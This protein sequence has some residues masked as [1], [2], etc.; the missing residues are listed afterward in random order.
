MSQMLDDLRIVC[1]ANGI[2]CTPADCS[3]AIA[4][5]RSSSS[6]SSSSS[7]SDSLSVPVFD[8]IEE[9]EV[10]LTRLSSMKVFCVFRNLRILRVLNQCISRIE[11][12]ER[13][14]QLQELWLPGNDITVIEGLDHCTALHTLILNENKIASVQGLSHLKQLTVLDLHA[15]QLATLDGI[16]QLTSLKRLNVAQNQ[17]TEAAQFLQSCNQLNEINLAGNLIHSPA[18]LYSIRDLDSLR[19]LN[20]RDADFGS[21]PLCEID[22]YHTLSR[23]LLCNLDVLD[24]YRLTSQLTSS[25][26][27]T[28]EN[29]HRELI[30]LTK[31]VADNVTEA[32]IQCR[33]A[34]C[35][36]SLPQSEADTYMDALDDVAVAMQDGY[37]FVHRL[38]LLARWYGPNITVLP[39]KDT[40]RLQFFESQLNCTPYASYSIDIP[41]RWVQLRE[42]M[43]RQMT[44][45][46]ESIQD[47]HFDNTVVHV[48]HASTLPHV[49][50]QFSKSRNYEDNR[51]TTVR[52]VPKSKF[53]NVWQALQSMLKCF[54][55]VAAETQLEIVERESHWKKLASHEQVDSRQHQLV[56]LC[57][58]VQ[59]SDL[60]IDNTNSSAHL[61]EC[62]YAL[63]TFEP[64]IGTEDFQSPVSDMKH[65]ETSHNDDAVSHKDITRIMECSKQLLENWCIGATHQLR[66]FVLSQLQFSEQDHRAADPEN[67]T[68]HDKASVCFVGSAYLQ[69]A[70]EWCERVLAHPQS[71][72][73]ITSVRIA[74]VGISDSCGIWD[75]L[76]VLP[77]VQHLDLS[78][79]Q[80]RSFVDGKSQLQL[81]SQLQ[82]LD[83]S[84]NDIDNSHLAHMHNVASFLTQ[85][86]H[87]DFRGNPLWEDPRYESVML[88]LFFCDDDS[89]D[90]FTSTSSTDVSVRCN[91][92]ASLDGLTASYYHQKGASLKTSMP[93]LAAVATS[94]EDDMFNWYALRPGTALYGSAN[95]VSFRFG[96]VRAD[97]HNLVHRHHWNTIASDETLHTLSAHQCLMTS[98]AAW[99]VQLPQLQHLQT[100]V[101]DFNMIDSLGVFTSLTQLT[102]LSLRYN[103]IS[104]LEGIQHMISLQRLFLAGNRISELE[105]L[106]LLRPLVDLE[107]LSLAGN[108]VAMPEPCSAKNLSLHHHAAQSQYELCNHPVH[109]SNAEVYRLFTVYA[110]TD[111]LTVLDGAGVL[112]SERSQS[113]IIYRGRLLHSE[114]VEAINKVSHYFQNDSGVV[115][116]CKQSSPTTRNTIQ[117]AADYITKLDLSGHQLRS[118]GIMSRFK[119][120]KLRILSL[121]DNSISN[122]NSLVPIPH[123]E[124][125][126][127]S[128]NNI[129]CVEAGYWL[130]NFPNL[131]MLE[132]KN[133][134]ISN[135]NA[136]HINELQHVVVL[137]LAHN[138]IRTIAPIKLPKLQHLDLSYNRISRIDADSFSAL[139]LL[140]GLALHH[141][142]MRS[143]VNIGP[144]PALRILDLSYNRIV[145]TSQ[146]V[147]IG[148]TRLC[149]N[150][151]Q[152][153]L[154]N[155]PMARKAAYRTV[156]VSS[157]PSLQKLDNVKVSIEDQERVAAASAAVIGSVPMS[158]NLLNRTVPPSSSTYTNS[159]SWSNRVTNVAISSSST[160]SSPGH[161]ISSSPHRHTSTRH[162]IKHGSSLI[163]PCHPRVEVNYGPLMVAAK[164]INDPAVIIATRKPTKP[165]NDHRSFDNR[166]QDY[167]QRRSL[168]HGQHQHKQ[169]RKSADGSDPLVIPDLHVSNLKLQRT[170]SMP[171]SAEPKRRSKS[172]TMM[173]AGSSIVNQRSRRHTLNGTLFPKLPSK[174]SHNVHPDDKYD[175]HYDG[176]KLPSSLAAATRSTQR[177]QPAARDKMS[178]TATTDPIVDAVDH[179]ERLF[180]DRIQTSFRNSTGQ[181]MSYAAV[182]AATATST[183]TGTGSASGAGPSS[184]SG[185]S[186]PD[187]ASNSVLAQHAKHFP[188]S[189]AAATSKRRRN[190]R[191]QH[192]MIMSGHRQAGSPTGATTRAPLADFLSSVRQHHVHASKSNRH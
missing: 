131:K 59:S 1:E 26:T 103:T 66:Q 163:R 40:A 157:I 156:I 149:T 171:L 178:A 39:A 145:D 165:Q 93:V 50:C 18:E 105:Q 14:T 2:I 27:A 64:L 150:L 25:A 19:M 119:F 74:R 116:H 43:R 106:T 95:D 142:E 6:S 166:R 127:V 128:S 89:D 191:T 33:R 133:N 118:I 77:S 29:T 123:L 42:V 176:I 32:W 22:S 141:N 144:L 37:S 124:V 134:N 108:P 136:M 97:G 20:F 36:D 67:I 31:S 110:C 117:D 174:T 55:G 111:S 71:Y 11:G 122:M 160:S 140:Q 63:C 109:L 130:S 21:N 182:V 183:T 172:R 113:H 86:E 92:V 8:E 125:L 35:S 152:L 126:K 146:I 179:A 73:S 17:L 13:C 137:S 189:A 23:Y 129:S 161:S 188:I 143:L 53:T 46:Y 5:T 99:K 170:K 75:V 94:F 185:R 15:N 96:V 180:S 87:I 84:F 184:L 49:P 98:S 192:N 45:K 159:A 38:A 57:W 52:Y 148:E 58:A 76:S 65:F 56:I 3:A 120:N 80:L 82:R 167:K 114:L 34:L 10:Y 85:L 147:F 155:N 47:A 177:K 181:T 173:A 138:S 154:N 158:T 112:Q 90:T 187:F 83:V 91:S 30:T 81:P 164:K 79:N 100:I 7:D 186:S 28:V 60:T 139:E 101:L 16:Q 121:E 132:L 168:R 78:H 51:F 169:K 44:C 24:Q 70:Q 135:L 153:R 88:S 107:H 54:A 151:E 62:P 104:S 4:L 72:Q 190:M 102:D 61:V 162:D 48:T 115:L 12:L 175:A 41:S 68:H 9:L 69:D